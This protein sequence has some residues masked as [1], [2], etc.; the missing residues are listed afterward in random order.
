MLVHAGAIALFWVAGIGH[1]P[2]FRAPASLTVRLV[3]G[4]PGDRAASATDEALETAHS[5][6]ADL[7]AQLSGQG[8]PPPADAA[9]PPRASLDE[10]MGA[11]GAPASA[12][13]GPA[14]GASLDDP[15]AR[16]SLI[17]AAP[18][19][20]DPV[21]AQARRCWSRTV[22][23]PITVQVRL[24]PDGR[25][26]GRPIVL[27]SPLARS[28]SGRTQDERAAVRAV[29]DCAPYPRPSPDGSTVEVILD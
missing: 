26:A 11:G 23:T 28:T 7:E 5:R 9:R 29:I 10:L 22:S 4:A 3:S 15:Y 25:I 14:G 12:A 2:A 13:N 19:L 18:P 21:G 16:A 1:G 27:R 20:R 17:S 24:R 8:A 6:F